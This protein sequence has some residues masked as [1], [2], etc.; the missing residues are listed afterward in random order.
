MKVVGFPNMGFNT[1]STTAW[2][3]VK[4]RVA[5]VLDNTGSMAQN[6]KIGALKKPSSE[7]A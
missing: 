3:N 5:M 4:M 6:G 1:T 2:G 7:A